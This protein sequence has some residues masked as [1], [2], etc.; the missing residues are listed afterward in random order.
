M[1]RFF[2]RSGPRVRRPESSPLRL[3][4]VPGPQ[5]P[6][7]EGSGTGAPAARCSSCSPCSRC[8]DPR[9]PHSSP[10]EG[11]DSPDPLHA[12]PQRVR[13]A[14]APSTSPPEGQYGSEPPT[15]L[16][17]GRPLI[18]L[19]PNS[20]FIIQNFFLTL[21]VQVALLVKEVYVKE[22]KVL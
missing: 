7:L 17:T 3:R 2:R 6:G 9:P 13:T 12:P 22:Y 5:L 16:N 19:V 8:S 15:S 14:Q 1:L 4:A 18:W 10:P 21:L 20:T 11:Q